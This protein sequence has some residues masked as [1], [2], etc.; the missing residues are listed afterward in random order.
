MRARFSLLVVAVAVVLHGS[1]I[2]GT[3]DAAPAPSPEAFFGFAM[4]A[5]GRLA[6]WTRMAEYFRVLARSTRR[7][8]V[9]ELGKTTQGRPYLLV[10]IASPETLASLA[11]IRRIGET[12]SAAAQEEGAG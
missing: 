5:E 4:G 10:T 9:E 1:P 8:R 3:R 12:L 6:D 2:G 7:V 11:D